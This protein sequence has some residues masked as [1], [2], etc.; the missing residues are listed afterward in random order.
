MTLILQQLNYENSS[1]V[2]I[3]ISNPNYQL[4]VIGTI[5]TDKLITS[6]LITSNLTVLGDK[7]ILNTTV[8]QT[9]ELEIIN[10]NNETAIKVQ[11]KTN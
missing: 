9:E 6:N 1:K 10:E 5:N 3:G 4:D 7:T 8:Y 11:Q 2:G